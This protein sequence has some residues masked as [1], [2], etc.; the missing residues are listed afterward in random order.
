MVV[1]ISQSPVRSVVILVEPEACLCWISIERSPSNHLSISNRSI[2]KDDIVITNEGIDI[3][4][5]SNCCGGQGRNS[6]AITHQ[7]ECIASACGIDGLVIAC[8]KSS[9]IEGQCSTIACFVHRL[10]VG[11]SS[12]R[13]IG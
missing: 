5:A 2:I 8:R 11:N 10:N 9:D 4:K 12:A 6:S 7:F 3:G 13:N 1:T